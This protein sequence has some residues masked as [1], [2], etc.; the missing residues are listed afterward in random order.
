MGR[1]GGRVALPAL[2]PPAALYG[3]N[4]YTRRIYREGKGGRPL[5]TFTADSFYVLIDLFYSGQFKAGEQEH[6]QCIVEVVFSYCHSAL[7]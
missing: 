6:S 2:L 4:I 5:S 3:W 7:F 1:A